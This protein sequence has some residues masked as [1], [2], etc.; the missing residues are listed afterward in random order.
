MKTKFLVNKY[1]IK[2]NKYY[3]NK[4]HNHTLEYLRKIIN[5]K[6]LIVTKIVID[7]ITYNYWENIK[8]N[9]NG[10]IYIYTNDKK[11]I[12]FFKRYEDVFFGK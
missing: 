8:Y 4:I 6:K 2:Y 5:R 10:T 12:K 1:H 11:T 9:I 7:K 3:S